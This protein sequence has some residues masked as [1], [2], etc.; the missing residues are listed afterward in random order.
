MKLLNELFARFDKLAAVS[1]LPLSWLSTVGGGRHP[2]G[3]GLPLPLLP[4]PHDFLPPSLPQ[5]SLPLTPPR[6]G[7]GASGPQSTPCPFRNTTSC[8]LRSWVTVTTASAGCLTTARTTPSAPSSW[9][10][11]WWRPSRKWGAAGGRQRGSQSM[12]PGPSGKLACFGGPCATQAPE[13][14]PSGY[15]VGA[16]SDG[17]FSSLRPCCLFCWEVPSSRNASTSHFLYFPPKCPPISSPCVSS[18]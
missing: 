18:S 15:D 10:S 7:G 5:R 4:G 17:G 3:L 1:T 11:P 6:R 13:E 9:G 2:R 16:A 8:G 14:G 12:G